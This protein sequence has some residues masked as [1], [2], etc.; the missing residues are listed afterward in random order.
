MVQDP[1][2]AEFITQDLPCSFVE[3]RILMVQ[4]MGHFL[5]PWNPWVHS[6]IGPRG[7]PIAPMDCGLRRTVH[8]PQT[9]G[10]QEH[11]MA[12]KGHKFMKSK[13]HPRPR[14]GQKGH[15]LKFHQKSP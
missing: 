4:A 6:E 10:P 8:V 13:E 11:Q 5:V 9:I 2:G 1:L 7:P 3:A 12:K 14:Q 15:K